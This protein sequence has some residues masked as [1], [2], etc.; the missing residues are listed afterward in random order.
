MLD[1][2]DIN[3]QNMYMGSAASM[4]NM[5]SNV[6][7]LPVGMGMPVGTS[8]SVPMNSLPISNI[9]ISASNAG[10]YGT[11]I[12]VNLSASSANIQRLNR[13]HGA[14]IQGTISPSEQSL[15]V[16]SAENINLVEEPISIQVPTS[17]TPLCGI[18]INNQIALGLKDGTIQIF[19][20]DGHNIS[21]LK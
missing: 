13:I 9:P 11:Y 7:G 20:C 16:N 3:N 4:G 2:L 15:R 18:Y 6:S 14:N 5:R 12:P 17:Q 1:G 10:N 19:S 8:M 21:T